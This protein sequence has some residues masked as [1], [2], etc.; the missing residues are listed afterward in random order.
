MQKHVSTQDIKMKLQHAKTAQE[1]N[2]NSGLLYKPEVLRRN[3]LGILDSTLVIRIC[4]H[5]WYSIFSVIH[6][7]TLQS[8]SSV[9]M[10]HSQMLLMQ[11]LGSGNQSD[12][13]IPNLNPEVAMKLRCRNP[14]SSSPELPN[15]TSLFW[16][17][18]QPAPDIADS[19]AWH[20]TV[21]LEPRVKSQQH[22]HTHAGMHTLPPYSCIQ[23]WLKIWR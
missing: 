6:D 9:L 8:L 7:T 15:T 11:K 22:I 21:S 18:N 19:T 2:I 5:P 13:D 12:Y 3:S 16:E 14:G 10:C 20:F 23:N 1:K 17:D 4:Q